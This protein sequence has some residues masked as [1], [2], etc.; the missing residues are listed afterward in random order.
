MKDEN[1]KFLGTVEP[2]LITS[3]WYNYSRN[4]PSATI[5]ELDRIYTE[6]TGTSLN[7]N[8]GCGNCILRLLKQCSRLYFK[9]LPD[10]I[11]ENLRDR[12]KI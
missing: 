11:P 5:R 12:K 7:T 3:F 4:L 2:E 6:E 8:F 10:R 1:L 9:E